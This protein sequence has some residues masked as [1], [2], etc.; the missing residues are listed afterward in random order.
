MKRNGLGSLY[1]R[2]TVAERFRLDVLVTARGDVRESEH[3]AATCPRFNY[4][5]NEVGFGVRWQAAKDL[6][7]VIYVSLS[8]TVEKLRLME[9][10]GH[11]ITSLG[12]WRSWRRTL[13]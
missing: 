9:G 2:L 5:M 13:G 10:F 3:L 8:S 11:I 1:D 7:T 12:D 6:A 4:T